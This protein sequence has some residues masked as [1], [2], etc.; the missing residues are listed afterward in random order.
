MTQT[1]HYFLPMQQGKQ[2]RK[3]RISCLP[4]NVKDSQTVCNHQEITEKNKQNRDNVVLPK[5]K[6]KILL[7]KNKKKKQKIRIE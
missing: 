5:T 6:K 3:K 4:V 7:S 2:K 1:Y